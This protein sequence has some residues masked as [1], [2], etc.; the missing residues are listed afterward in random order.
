MNSASVLLTCFASPW[1]TMASVTSSLPV[2][3][4]RL[5]LRVFGP[6][7]PQQSGSLATLDFSYSFEIPLTSTVK[8]NSVSKILNAFPH[9][10]NQS[11][12][13]LEEIYCSKERRTKYLSSVKPQ[14]MK[15]NGDF[16]LLNS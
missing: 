3:E 13:G 1:T 5:K 10:F 15:I 8:K 16:F 9:S 2:F 14:I 4:S 6:L 12:K 11:T 7:S